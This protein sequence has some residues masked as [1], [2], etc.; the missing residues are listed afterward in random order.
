[1]AKT[2]YV[3]HG[4]DD[5]ARDE[6]V[7]KMRTGMGDSTEAQMNTSSFDGE[8]ATVPE[9]I[10]AVRSYP[11][12]ADKRLAIVRNMLTYLTRKGAG[13]SGKKGIERL[14]EELPT[15]PDYARLVFVED[16]ALSA[17]HKIL[18]LANKQ[19]YAKEFPLPKDATQWIIQRAK[20]EYQTDIE[21]RAAF[22]LATVTGNDLRRADNELFKLVC[23]TEAL[24]PISEVDVAL[25][26]PYVAEANIF[27]MID[28]LAAQNGKVALS[29]IHTALDQNE[30]EFRLFARIVTQFRQLLLTREHLGAGGSPKDLA[31]LLKVHPYPAEKLAKQSRN[32]TLEQLEMIYRRL[33]NYDQDMKT[34]NIAPVLALDLLVSGLAKR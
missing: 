1:M 7:A 29:L 24:R 23:Y 34:G 11:F 31:A 17:T 8:Q 16:V 4:E 33:Q 22:A 9:V 19:G 30:D 18:D 32:F 10:G 12:L 6:A 20:N 5:M 13:E 27:E 21:G 25:L 15:L 14:L 26:T 28:A 3:L 2:F